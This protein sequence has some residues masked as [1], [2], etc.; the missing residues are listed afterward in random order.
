MREMGVVICHGRGAGHEPI[1][2]RR[3]SGQLGRFVPRQLGGAGKRLDRIT[4]TTRG[5]FVGPERCSPGV[6]TARLG[7][8]ATGNG[9]VIAPPLPVHCSPL[10]GSLLPIVRVRLAIAA[11]DGRERAVSQVGGTRESERFRTVATNH[12]EVS[13]RF[14]YRKALCCTPKLSL[15]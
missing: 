7:A 1:P 3:T 4:S 10:R 12:L 14:R 5:I 13:F 8:Y 11:K 15:T 9:G 2:H 6:N